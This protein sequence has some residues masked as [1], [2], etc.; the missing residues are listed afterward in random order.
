MRGGAF[1]ESGIVFDGA[2]SKPLS[3]SHIFDNG[4]GSLEL[5]PSKRAGPSRRDYANLAEEIGLR[6]QIYDSGQGVS[7]AIDRTRIDVYVIH[8]IEKVFTNRPLIPSV[9]L[10]NWW[11]LLRS[12]C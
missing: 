1:L 8:E 3:V 4:L 2:S 6:T 5:F 10:I 12:L 11:A 7:M 9:V